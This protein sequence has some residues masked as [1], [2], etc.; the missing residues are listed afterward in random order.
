MAG[1]DAQVGDAKGLC[2]LNVFQLA[3]LQRL[4]A[5]Q[6]RQAGPAGQAE[7]ETQRQQTQVGALGR[8]GKPLWM[9]VD[10]DLHHQHGRSDQQ[11]A[12]NRIE[13][14]IDILDQVINPA[15]EIARNDAE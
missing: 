9:G 2:C 5:Q 7:D 1:D 3:Q 10:H 14:G 12:G 4:A 8:R 6:A 13:R 11:H 15:A